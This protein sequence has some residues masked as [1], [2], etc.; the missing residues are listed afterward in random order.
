MDSFPNDEGLTEE[1]AMTR[2]RSSTTTEMLSDRTRTHEA[3][4]VS[5]VLHAIPR[6]EDRC[7]I[8]LLSML[9]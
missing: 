7:S 1:W 3:R 5:Q 4:G 9:P 6:A 8:Y 2:R